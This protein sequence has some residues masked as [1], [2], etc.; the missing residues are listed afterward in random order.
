MPYKSGVDRPPGRATRR[1]RI[2]SI[3]GPRNHECPMAHRRRPTPGWLSWLQYAAVRA[4][5]AL[6]LSLPL[7]LAVRAAEG[8]ALLV[9]AIDAKHRNAAVRNVA[10]AYPTWSPA[11][12]EA[13]VR[14]TYRHLA[15]MLV[16]ILFAPRLVRR[17]NVRRYMDARRLEY[18]DRAVR[19]GRGAVLVIGHQGNW[20]FIGYAVT[21]MGYPLH[22]IARPLDNPLIDRFLNRFRTGTGQAVA[23]KYNVLRQMGE[24]LQQN[25]IVIFLADQDARK[26]GLFVPFFGRPASTFKA[27]AVVAL[28]YGVPLLVAD[29]YRDGLMHH[30]GTV[31]PPLEAPPGLRGEEAVRYLVEAYTRMLE[32]FIR[33]HPEQYL[34]LH[35]R[36]KTRP[37]EELA[38]R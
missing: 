2:L 17:S 25:K 23:S 6:L 10:A 22:A 31:H 26:H 11:A 8:L 20:E 30:I 38:G 14:R 3:A 32:S 16:E 13:L 19:A 34:W 15:A 36:W 28:R 21:L 4:A 5:A 9:A 33:R 35:R 18:F 12:C 7:R 27:P 29:L 37:P 1:G 24:F